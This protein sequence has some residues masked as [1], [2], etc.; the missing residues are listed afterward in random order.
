VP[1]LP[2]PPTAGT[3]SSHTCFNYGH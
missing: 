3:T 1:R 2:T